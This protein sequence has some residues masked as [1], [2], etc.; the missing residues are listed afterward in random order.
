[1]PGRKS[2]TVSFVKAKT[3][4]LKACIDITMASILGENYFSRDVAEGILAEGIAEKQVMVAKTKSGEIVGF[5]RLVLDGFCLVFA[6][7]NVLAVKTEYRGYGIG[8]KLITEAEREILHEKGYPFI[9]KSF[10]L[11]G[12][13]NRK[14]LRFYESNGYKRSSSLPNLF[15]E[16]DTEYLMM[17]ELG[18][19]T[20]KG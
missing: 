6:Y 8:T 9:K 15:S 13:T 14:A 17:K 7:I 2:V 12:K 16:G 20:W 3:R 19:G 1:M 5:Y 4:D 18:E 11:V 10:L